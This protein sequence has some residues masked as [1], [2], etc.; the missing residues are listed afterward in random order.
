[1]F[2]KVL[3]L[4]VLLFHTLG[5]NTDGNPLPCYQWL[6]LYQY[7]LVNKEGIQICFV[8]RRRRR[9]NV[10]VFHLLCYTWHILYFHNFVLL[11]VNG[12][13]RVAQSVGIYIECQKLLS[14]SL[15]E[16]KE[17]LSP[18]LFHNLLCIMLLLPIVIFILLA[19]SYYLSLV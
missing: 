12:L 6:K 18:L 13:K 10:S 16:T 14:V 11:L 9:A 1:M 2:R 5:G 4:L 15:V 7:I 3:Y 19:L 17:K 8:K